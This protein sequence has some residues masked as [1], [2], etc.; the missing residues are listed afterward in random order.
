MEQAYS[1]LFAAIAKQKLLQKPKQVQERLTE[2]SGRAKTV[3]LHAK[4][5][6]D[7]LKEEAN[8]PQ[9][10][11]KSILPP[12]TTVNNNRLAKFQRPAG[13]WVGELR[14]PAEYKLSPSTRSLTPRIR[15][16]RGAST[17]TS[18]ATVVRRDNYGLLGKNVGLGALGTV[19]KVLTKTLLSV[20]KKD[21]PTE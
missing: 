9:I 11:A 16:K 19:A 18:S 6:M 10:H 13:N 17:V 3:I 8:D 21:R 5:L 2:C 7:F 1:G 12:I 15:S 14:I 4:C 20:K